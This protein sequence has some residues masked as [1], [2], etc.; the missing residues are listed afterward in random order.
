MITTQVRTAGMNLL[1]RQGKKIINALAPKDRTE[2]RIA[3][4]V[5]FLSGL[6][7]LDSHLGK[8]QNRILEECST[9]D[10]FAELMDFYK[11]QAE[12]ED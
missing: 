4:T 5:V 12:E 10:A 8:A 9:G 1:F 7:N 11:G 2:N 6:Y 3:D